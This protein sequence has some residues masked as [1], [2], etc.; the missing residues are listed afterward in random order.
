MSIK[1]S[2]DDMLT[3]QRKIADLM[4]KVL[5]QIPFLD[6][7]DPNLKDTPNRI[8]RA[9]L[10]MFW[11]LDPDAGPRITTFPVDGETPGLVGTGKIFFTSIC[12]HHFLP[13]AG[14]AHVYY[15]PDEKIVGL[16]KFTR[17]V[18]YYAARPQIQ[19]RL[20]VQI[21]DHIMKVSCCRGC[22]VALRAT[23]SCMQ[24]R[25]VRQ[26]GAVMVTP[27]IRPIDKRGEPIGPFA[28]AETRNE[29]LALM[30]MEK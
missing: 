26:E 14:H 7:D 13:F 10:E 15:I 9:Y 1:N 2:S 18:N 25:G 24:C 27:V 16:S 23:H 12:A 5:Q 11:G 21:A 28:K 30:E 4:G 22:F 19:E 17:I 8:A 3:R 6:L 20:A 29:A